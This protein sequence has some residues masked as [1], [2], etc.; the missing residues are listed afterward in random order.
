MLDGRTV[1]VLS[2]KPGTGVGEVRVDFHG[3]AD[4]Q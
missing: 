3:G 4:F 1:V 2:F